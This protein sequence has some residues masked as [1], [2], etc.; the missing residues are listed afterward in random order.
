[1]KKKITIKVES[2]ADNERIKEYVKGFSRDNFK[3]TFE[4]IVEDEK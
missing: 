4:V 1:M 2:E 3:E